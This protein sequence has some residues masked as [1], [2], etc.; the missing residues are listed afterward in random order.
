MSRMS[1][2]LL[3][4]MVLATSGCYAPPESKVGLSEPG[5]DYDHRLIGAWNSVDEDGR[6]AIYLQ[7]LRGEQAASLNIIGVAT[8]VARRQDPPQPVYWLT[9]TAYAS[10]IGSRVYYNVQC[11]AGSGFDYTA[12]GERPGFIILEAA[13]LDDATLN[14]CPMYAGKEAARVPEER[15]RVVDGRFGRS[16]GDAKYDQYAVLELSRDELVALVRDMPREALFICFPP[17][18]KVSMT[19]A[20]VWPK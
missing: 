18:H 9:A 20:E 5:E 10:R 4:L 2:Y 13:L 6:E 1:R 14:L 12:E 3:I 15:R 17:F 11:V 16:G 8:F 7:I 19:N